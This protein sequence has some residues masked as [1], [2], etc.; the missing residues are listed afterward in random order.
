[1]N[2]EIA[3]CV[4]PSVSEGKSAAE[5]NARGAPEEGESDSPIVTHTHL[6]NL[7]SGKIGVPADLRLFG[8]YTGKEESR[9]EAEAAMKAVPELLVSEV[10]DRHRMLA[11][12][13]KSH[14]LV[15][16]SKM[17]KKGD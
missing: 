2:P 12:Y 3:P 1:L 4:V 17:E 7:A 10:I 5:E 14:N 9:E 6:T 8:Q 15:K 11:E 13:V 16:V